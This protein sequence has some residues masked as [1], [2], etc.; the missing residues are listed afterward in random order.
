MWNHIVSTLPPAQAGETPPPEKAR[1]KE[2][3]KRKES[4]RSKDGPPPDPW[5]DERSHPSAFLTTR[6][7]RLVPW[8]FPLEWARK[9]E[10]GVLG[11]WGTGACVSVA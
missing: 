5:E 4:G 9:G 8:P 10:R 2:R 7:N 3:E 6:L 1:E 11:E